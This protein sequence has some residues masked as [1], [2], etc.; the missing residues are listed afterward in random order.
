MPNKKSKRNN[1][2]KTQHPVI[3]K[4]KVHT[5]YYFNGSTF[6]TFNVDDTFDN[7][8]KNSVKMIINGL[9]NGVSKEEQIQDY[10]NQLTMI[11]ELLY[12]HCNP[13]TKKGMQIMCRKLDQKEEK[14]YMIWCLNICALLNL[15][16]LANDN[17]NG[18]LHLTGGALKLFNSQFKNYKYPNGTEHHSR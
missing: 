6:P 15:N 9:E 8:S 5:L 2:N 11:E 16:A 7:F 10:K 14:L 3:E 17:D 12:R 4:V 1:N 18:V 13:Y